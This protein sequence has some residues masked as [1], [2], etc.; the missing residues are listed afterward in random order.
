M[1]ISGRKPYANKKIS[2][3]PAF[4]SGAKSSAA[5]NA[6]KQDFATFCKIRVCLSNDTA[7]LYILEACGIPNADLSDSPRRSAS[8]SS[9]HFC[10]RKSQ[11][12]SREGDV[13]GANLRKADLTET[14][15]TNAKGFN[16]KYRETPANLRIGRYV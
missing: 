2:F 6:P 7:T 5:G 11:A 10:Q 12:N 9:G 13:T 8:L 14:D 1:H 16:G 15:F 4:Q 3:Q